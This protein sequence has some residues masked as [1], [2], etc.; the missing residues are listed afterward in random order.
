MRLLRCRYEAGT[1][2]RTRTAWR[3]E[4]A[5]LESYFRTRLSQQAL[6]SLQWLWDDCENATV[7][8]RSCATI[9]R[10]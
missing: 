1:R 10:K 7:L 8:S 2:D 3:Q 5:E 9:G 6:S 4:R